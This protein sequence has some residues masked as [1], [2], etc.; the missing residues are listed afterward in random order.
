[1]LLMV[2]AGPA[3]AELREL[4][5]GYQTSEEDMME[6][7]RELLGAG[8][9][10]L[11]LQDPLEGLDSETSEGDEERGVDGRELVFVSRTG[12]LVDALDAGMRLRMYCE[13]LPRDR[14]AMGVVMG[15][16]G[17]VGEL[18]RLCPRPTLCCNA[19]R[20]PHPAF[21]TPRCA[22]LPCRSPPH[23]LTLRPAPPTAATTR[24]VPSWP[25]R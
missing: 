6:V 12:C 9:G 20:L 21:L 11:E 3:G 4:L 5:Q 13:S 15:C 24:R 25:L 22:R 14:C 16:G 18:A 8:A 19:P 17:E 1:M 10:L 23:H 2:P 7:A